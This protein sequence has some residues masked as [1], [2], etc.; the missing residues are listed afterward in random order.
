MK[1]RHGAQ[2][3]GGSIFFPVNVFDTGEVKKGKN[4]KC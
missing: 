4:S 2:A 1:L 3:V